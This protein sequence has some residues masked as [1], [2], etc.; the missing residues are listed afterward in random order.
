VTN[1]D[2]MST[3]QGGLGINGTLIV[4]GAAESFQV[5]PL[6]LIAGRRS[7]KVGIPAQRWIRRKLSPSA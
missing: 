6:L 5:S 3:V 4:I 1:G 2:A 7:S